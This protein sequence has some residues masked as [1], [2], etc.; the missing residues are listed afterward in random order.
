MKGTYLIW[1]CI[2]LISF[3]TR[4][5]TL[6]IVTENFPDFQYQNEKGE[7]IGRAADKVRAV[8]DSSGIDYTINV[9]SWPAAY[10]AALRKSDT[11]VFSTA[12]NNAREHEFEWVFPIDAFTTSFYALR[13]REIQ[14]TS[15]EDAKAYR[16]AVIRENFSH[17]FLMEHG[18]QEGRQLLIINSFDKVFELLKTR[19][20]F[21]DLV[22]LSDAQF[23]FRSTNEKTARL[24]EPVY[25]LDEF[26]TSLYLACNK[27]VPKYILNKI[28]DAYQALY[29]EGIL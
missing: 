23:R 15:I 25:T 17:Q 11:C 27:N 28:G 6:N 22:V 29:A 13:E 10:N 8:L 1:F 19:K 4:A 5:F 24:L 3:S 2:L 14:L 7:L 16:T 20:D 21:V 18:F 9:L 12:K 26:N